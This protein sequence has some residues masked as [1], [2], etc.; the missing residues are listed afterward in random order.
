MSFLV[1]LPLT[2]LPLI[3]YNVVVFGM[4]GG[5]G[6]DPWATEIISI[7]M[8]SGATFKMVLGDL[9]VTGALF[10]LFIE[11]LKATRTGVSALMDHILSVLVFVVYLIEF[12]IA[13]P[14]AT[15][16]FFILMVISLIDVI[17]GF[18]ISITGARRDV[19]FGQG[20]MH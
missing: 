11:M 3:A 16:I 14:A 20:G 4:T 5:A 6:G 1:S 18:S 12:L 9:V 19:S 2:L 7:N 17:A 10:L 15:S 13:A 8:V